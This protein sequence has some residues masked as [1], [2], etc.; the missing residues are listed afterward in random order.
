[1]TFRLILRYD[2]PNRLLRL[3]RWTWRVGTMGRGGYSAKFTVGLRPALF[4][5]ARDLDGWRL[6]IMG[7]RLH[8][9]RAYGGV[10]SP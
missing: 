4:A 1:M 8:Y 6:T 2:P 10:H 5:F 3:C 7:I 9:D